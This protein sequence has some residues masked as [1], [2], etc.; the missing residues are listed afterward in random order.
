MGRR[1]R[2]LLV[3][4]TLTLVLYAA[5]AINKDDNGEMSRNRNRNSSS[6]GGGSGRVCVR[7]R[8]ECTDDFM[9]MTY[10]SPSSSSSGSESESE[11]ES[12]GNSKKM[13]CPFP[14]Y[15]DK[16][17]RACIQDSTGASCTRD[18][19]CQERPDFYGTGLLYCDV[20]K[21]RS[22]YNAGDKCRRSSDCA[23]GMGCAGGRCVGH[24]EGKTCTETL[25]YTD[26]FFSH[27]TGYT[28]AQG[29][30]C[31]HRNCTK[32]AALNEPCTVIPCGRGLACNNGV[33]IKKYSVKLG[34]PCSVK[35]Q[36]TTTK[37]KT[38]IYTLTRYA[39]I[40]QPT[41]QP[42]LFYFIYLFIHSE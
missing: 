5:K 15:C 6:R 40:N 7:T 24:T 8:E 20:G 3:G 19:D 12:K 16:E 42:S 10:R 41:N 39:Y 2:K 38:F 22:R 34:L 11:S 37:K 36:T 18:E 29:L 25:P 17:T 14:L 35:K 27:I 33:C 13:Y 31:V 28:C 4:F 23:G 21:C 9:N 26:K 1:R 32:P 30:V